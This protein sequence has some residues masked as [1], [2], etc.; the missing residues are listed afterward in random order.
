M[1][2]F[3]RAQCSCD[4]TAN[5]AANKS[6]DQGKSSLKEEA[7]PENLLHIS[8]DAQYDSLLSVF[9]RNMMKSLEG[10]SNR[11]HYTPSKRRKVALMRDIGSCEECRQKKREV[12]FFIP[13]VSVLDPPA[14]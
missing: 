1:D 7:D 8:A 13:I 14:Q 11:R 4:G 9:N 3:E 12:S 10:K 5:S 6:T 2:E